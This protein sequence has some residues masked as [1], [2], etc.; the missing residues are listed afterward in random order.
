MHQFT[1]LRFLGCTSDAAEASALVGGDDLALNAAMGPVL[2]GS[3][4]EVLGTF[5]RS[6][7]PGQPRRLRL[8]L[9]A[10]GLADS[11]GTER[12]LSTHC[13]VGVM[14]ARR[15][16]LSQAVL[17]AL[18]HA[19][20]R[21]DGKGFPA[22]LAGEAVPL[23][24]RVAVVARDADLATAQG[25]DARAWTRERSGRA[26]D[27]SVVEAFERAGPDVLAALAGSDEWETALAGE[28]GPRRPSSRT[29]ST[30]F[31]PRSRTSPTSSRPGS[32]AIP[33]VSPRSP[34]RQAAT[35][36]STMPRAMSCGRRAWCTTSAG[37]PSKTGSG[38]SLAR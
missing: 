22:G 35:P 9:V 1:L 25:E 7:A 8:G 24:V 6:V 13:E 16:S 19:Y 12:S 26:Y 32:A 37:S 4:R 20:E 18:A 17:E 11:K 21:W 14:L 33:A 15:I 36:G 30:T 23:A 27:P 28:P 10:R 5:V 29:G 38:T 2:M 34:R 3:T 31:S